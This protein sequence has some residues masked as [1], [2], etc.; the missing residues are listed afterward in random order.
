MKIL[1]L[2]EIVGKAGLMA[3][4]SMLKPVVRD[5]GVDLVIANAEG[6]TSGFGLGVK[7]AMTLFKYGID[8]LTGGE[9]IFYK[10]EMQEFINRKDR[11]LRPANYPE[12]APG[13]GLKYL[14]VGT[15]K[16]CVLNLLGMA[17][18]QTV[19]LANPFIIADNLMDKILAETP[20]VLVVFHASMTAEKGTMGYLL[21]GRASAVIGTHCKVMSADSRI[22]EHGTAFI[23][24]NG[25]C[26][27]FMSVG[28]FL[29]ENEIYKMTYGTFRRSFECF[30]DNRLQGVIVTLGDDGRAQAIEPV[31]MKCTDK[32]VEESDR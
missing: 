10:L 19:H 26:G 22:L 4:K 16:V 29:P 6:V 1:F 2:G 12:A 31:N 20:F 27:S 7:H 11:I 9:K 8:I 25:R 15:Q 28:G 14:N 3:V 32:S 17:D 18:M 23:S 21:D 5:N 30:D 13:R 24:D